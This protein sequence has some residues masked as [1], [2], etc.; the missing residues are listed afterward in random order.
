MI[1]SILSGLSDVEASAFL[2]I[3]ERIVCSAAALFSL[4][5]RGLHACNDDIM[6]LFFSGFPLLCGTRDMITSIIF[7]ILTTLK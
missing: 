7:T 3:R 4:F 6:L 2:S 1:V 5:M